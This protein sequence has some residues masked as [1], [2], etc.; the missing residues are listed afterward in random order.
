MSEN[1]ISVT[2][3][4]CAFMEINN[5]LYL[6]TRQVKANYVINTVISN[7]DTLEDSKEEDSV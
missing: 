3:Q 7:E 5:I 4:L 1:N 2:D 6:E